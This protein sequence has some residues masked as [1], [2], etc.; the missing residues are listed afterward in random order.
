[1]TPY[2]KPSIP[3]DLA[4]QMVD[5]ALS[6]ASK[7]GIQISVTILDESGIIKAFARMDGSP[8]V[9]VEVSRMKAWTSVGFGVPTGQAWVDHSRGDFILEQGILS[10]PNF[11]MLGG[12]HPV[13]ASGVVAGAIGVSG[14]HYSQ[15]DACTQAAVQVWND[16]MGAPS[17]P[18][19][20]H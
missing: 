1:M 7:I 18:D 8:L 17:T 2:L 19:A 4:R 3:L 5:A 15:D 12:G 14:A 6:H 9:A 16:A 10:L 20:H 11:T 13:R